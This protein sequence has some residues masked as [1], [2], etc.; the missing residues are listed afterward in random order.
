MKL[1]APC[2]IGACVFLL[3]CCVSAFAQGN[4]FNTRGNILNFRSVQ[5]P[6]HRSES[7]QSQGGVA[8]RQRLKRR[9]TSFRCRRDDAQRVAFFTLIAGTGAPPAANPLVPTAV[10][11]TG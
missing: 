6:C 5:Q 4:D 10:R 2:K 7:G 9:R 8:L 3:A 1:S 11:T